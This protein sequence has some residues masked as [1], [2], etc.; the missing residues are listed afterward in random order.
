MTIGRRATIGFAIMMLFV[1][2]SSGLSLYL[3]QRSQT[4]LNVFMDS[5]RKKDLQAKLERHILDTTLGYMDAIVDKDSATIADEITQA[6]DSLEVEV[7]STTAKDVG[8]SEKEWQ[9]FL[10]LE[11]AYSKQGQLMFSDIRSKR[12]DRFAEHDDIIDGNTS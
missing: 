11:E 7:K 12:N 8:I 4:S 5:S 1:I 6:V 10:K 2:I 3:N 9:D